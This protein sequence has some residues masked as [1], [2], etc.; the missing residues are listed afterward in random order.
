MW[1]I[2]IALGVFAAFIHWPIR[3]RAVARLVAAETA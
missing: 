1:L 2:S 3:E